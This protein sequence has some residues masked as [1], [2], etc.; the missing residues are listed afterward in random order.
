M[1]T[2]PPL[3]AYS[4]A[5]IAARF[6]SVDLAMAPMPAVQMVMLAVI[7]SAFTAPGGSILVAFLYYLVYVRA[8]G[9]GV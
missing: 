7:A 4:P 1:D 6:E 5:Q 2:P 9:K 8:G 3:D